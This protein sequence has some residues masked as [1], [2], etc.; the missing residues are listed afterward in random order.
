MTVA[1]G[2]AAEWLPQATI[3][4]DRCAVNRRLLVELGE[5]AWFLGVESLIF[6]RA[7]MGETVEYASLHDVIQV[8]RGGRLLLRDAIRLDGEV[9]ATLRRPAIAGGAQAVA[10]LVHVAPGAAEMLEPL[11]ETFR[12]G[13]GAQCGSSAWDGMLVARILAADSASLQTAVIAALRTLRSDRPLP[14]VWLC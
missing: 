6:G 12:S 4:F 14:R 3:L 7:A 8:R 2:G 1:D 11:R 5:G 9:A 10:T 13:R